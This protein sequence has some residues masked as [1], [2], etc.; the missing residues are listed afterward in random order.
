MKREIDVEDLLMRFKYSPG[1]HVKSSVL[2]RFND[3]LGNGKVHG[4]AR[5]F[6][7]M[8]VPLY[9][10]VVVLLLAAGLSFFAGLSVRRQ[11]EQIRLLNESSKGRVAREISWYVTET[12]L[13]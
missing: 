9:A 1:S 7:R 8:P 12:D 10:T 5:G 2:A 3:T 11:D 13:L 4:E 6:W